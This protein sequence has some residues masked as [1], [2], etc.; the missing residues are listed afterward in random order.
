MPQPSLEP[1]ILPPLPAQDRITS[2]RQP[3]CLAVL[4]LLTSLV[5]LPLNMASLCVQSALVS[6]FIRTPF[7][8][9]LR[10]ELTEGHTRGSCYTI[11]APPSQ[12]PQALDRIWCH[13]LDTLASPCHSEGQSH[14]SIHGGS[15]G[16]RR[17]LADHETVRFI[18][19]QGQ[20]RTPLCSNSSVFPVLS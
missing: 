20:P 17:C 16:S 18:F 10:A 11:L 8:G 6:L 2:M 5:C 9:R 4:C 19:R 15:L 3:P 13:V 12:G 14:V 7:T 1:R